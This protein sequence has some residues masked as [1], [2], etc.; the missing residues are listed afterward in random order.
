MRAQSRWNTDVY[1]KEMLHKERRPAFIQATLVL[2]ALNSPGICLPP[3]SLSLALG[4]IKAPHLQ[5]QGTQA[6]RQRPRDGIQQ[7]VCQVEKLKLLQG[8]W[9]H[10][11]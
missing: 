6:Q 10:K 3:C 4:L 7:V 9:G 1:G 5:V 8:L 2:A 11:V